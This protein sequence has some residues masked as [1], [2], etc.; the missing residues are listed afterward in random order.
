M[1]KYSTQKWL[2]GTRPEEDRVTRARPLTQIAVNEPF[3]LSQDNCW[4]KPNVD[5]KNS[6]KDSHGDAC[7]NCRLVE[8]P[9][10]RDTDGDG[11]G[12]ACDDDMD[13]DGM[14]RSDIT[15]TDAHAYIT[16]ITQGA[17][18]SDLSLCPPP[19]HSP[20]LHP[21]SHIKAFT[22]VQIVQSIT[23]SL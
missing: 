4:L 9:D 12:D 8:N 15:G 22:L 6:D 3:V 14:E 21:S 20:H 10:Q 2:P 13:G 11:K 7:D 23:P 16:G 19:S 5:Q 1:S 18:C 17:P